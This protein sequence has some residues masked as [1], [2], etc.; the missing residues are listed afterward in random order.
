[1]RAL[2]ALGD[3]DDL[4]RAPDHFVAERA[5]ADASTGHLVDV[6]AR[7]ELVLE[8]EL[9]L[10]FAFALGETALFR[11]FGDRVPVDAGA[12]VGAR[13]HG[14]AGSEIATRADF[15]AGRLAGLSAR[16]RRL[17]AVVDG[18]AHDVNER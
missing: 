18:V 11:L 15:A 6:G 5:H 4:A 10:G 7:R 9:F 3:D 1:R 12:I 16:V 2:T 13:V 14:A 17:D 8:E